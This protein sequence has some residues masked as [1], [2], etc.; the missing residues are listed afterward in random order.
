MVIHWGRELQV[1]NGGIIAVGGS[2]FGREIVQNL[3]LGWGRV[4]GQIM[5]IAA[6]LG[7]G[8]LC[9]DGGRKNRVSG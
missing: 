7:N 6:G 5:R 1:Q 9:G 8:A 2:V 4:Q 3:T